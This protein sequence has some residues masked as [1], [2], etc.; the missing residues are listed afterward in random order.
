MKLSELS[1]IRQ[2]ERESNPVAARLRDQYYDERRRK[3][4]LEVLLELSLP[5]QSQAADLISEH[6]GTISR[7]VAS[8][9]IATN[10]E[11]GHDCRINLFSLL[12]FKKTRDKRDLNKISDD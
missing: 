5:T 10:G 2:R 9:R 8:G 7:A 3:M 11:K 6:P 1:E 12:E 4:R